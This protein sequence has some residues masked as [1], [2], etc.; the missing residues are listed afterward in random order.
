[1]THPVNAGEL[2]DWLAAAGIDTTVWGENGAK[3]IEDLWQE[4]Q[5]GDCRLLDGP[6]RRDVSVVEVVLR[7]GNRVLLELGQTLR[8][9]QTRHRNR[10]P[11][12]KLKPGEDARGGAMRC[13]QEELEVSADGVQ[14][15]TLNQ[16]PTITDR[17]SPSYPG[18]PTR[19]IVYTATAVVPGLPDGDFWRENTATEQSDPVLRHQWGWREPPLED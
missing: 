17:D 13:L 14:E 6:P 11:S 16:T 1:M 15:L 2:A 5:Q 10:P 4:I 8:D 19:Y 7:R 9:G 3:H 18:L 12:E